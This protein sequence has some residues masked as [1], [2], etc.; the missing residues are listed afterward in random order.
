VITVQK[1]YQNPRVRVRGCLHR[2]LWIISFLWSAE[3]DLCC[4]TKAQRRPN[5]V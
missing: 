1:L 3:L 2:R 4:W 5:F